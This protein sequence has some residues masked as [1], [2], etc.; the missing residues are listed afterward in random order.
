ML[1][2]ISYLKWIY[3]EQIGPL[4]TQLES[5]DRP[6]KVRR[7]LSNRGG[8]HVTSVSHSPESVIAI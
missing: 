4:H 7:H 6:E 8:A 2:Y 3:S 5:I 1:F